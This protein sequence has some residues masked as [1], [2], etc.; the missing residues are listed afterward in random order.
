MRGRR[1]GRRR[2]R[3]SVIS[4]DGDVEA[5]APKWR[6]FAERARRIRGLA[7][8]GLPAAPSGGKPG[9]AAGSKMGPRDLNGG[10]WSAAH[11]RAL[12]GAAG[13]DQAP[14]AGPDA[15]VRRGWFVHGGARGWRRRP[16]KKEVYRLP[17]VADR[18]SD[19]GSLRRCGQVGRRSMRRDRE[20]RSWP[21]C[22]RHGSPVWTRSAP[23]YGPAAHACRISG[24]TEAPRRMP[25]AVRRN[26]CISDDK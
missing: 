7:R 18:V 22:V 5:C 16:V 21:A 13:R 3:G 14:L 8:D 24:H 17:A 10:S 11:V 19:A 20:N 25:R 9:S 15:G 26:A 23:P 12:G 6:A 2:S 1:R 4:G